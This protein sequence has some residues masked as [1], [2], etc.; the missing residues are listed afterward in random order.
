MKTFVV[1]DWLYTYAGSERVLESILECFPVERI[2]A[3]VDF[4][5]KPTRHFL[6]GIPVTTFVKPL[7]EVDRAVIDGEAEGFVKIHVKKGT[8][9]IVGA[10]IVARHAGEMISEVTCA[11]AGK[12]GLAALAG[13]GV[14][15]APDPRHSDL[16]RA[17]LR[18]HGRGGPAGALCRRR[19]GA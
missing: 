5:P 12:V 16:D 7:S 14:D 4:L 9:K 15:P 3:L 13:S 18:G 11:M 1:H 19:P 8:D 17:G 10:T 2:F 6:R